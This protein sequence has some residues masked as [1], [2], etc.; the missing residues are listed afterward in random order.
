LSNHTTTILGIS[1]GAQR[2]TFEV[3]YEKDGKKLQAKG[4]IPYHDGRIRCEFQILINWIAQ[5]I[6]SGKL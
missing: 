1:I 4:D 6:E 5:M 2:G 3:A